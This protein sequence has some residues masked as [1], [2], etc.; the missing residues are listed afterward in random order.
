MEQ[1]RSEL[2]GQS[3][4]ERH[5]QS[6]RE[7]ERLSTG[8]SCPNE[9]LGLGMESSRWTILH[10]LGVVPRDGRL[11]KTWNTNLYDAID[12]FLLCDFTSPFLSS[13]KFVSEWIPSLPP[14]LALF[15]VWL[16]KH[17][18][19]RGWREIF[20]TS[21][22]GQCLSRTLLL[23]WKAATEDTQRLHAVFVSV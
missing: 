15:R 17:L 22:T 5:T 13:S 18:L 21:Q 4:K 23:W 7:T 8:S 14:L 19:E 11:S 9:A 10:L 3:L 1:A 2:E 20:S 16:G 12:V 6:D